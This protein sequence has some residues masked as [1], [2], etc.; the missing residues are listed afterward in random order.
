M[1]LKP[2]DKVGLCSESVKMSYRYFVTLVSTVEGL[3]LCRYEG[4]EAGRQISAT[5]PTLS[6]TLAI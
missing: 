2:G 3:Q 5:K 1:R 4:S 6:A